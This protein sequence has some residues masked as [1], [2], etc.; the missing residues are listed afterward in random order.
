MTLYGCLKQQFQIDVIRRGDY[1]SR[2]LEPGLAVQT[3]RL[4]VCDLPSR[5]VS[6]CVG[7]QLVR[8][9]GAYL[10]RQA[11]LR[12]RLA[13]NQLIRWADQDSL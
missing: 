1:N 4:Y 9:L 5:Q 12:G 7:R 8:E 13:I 10:Q 2:R 6:L 3:F 11:D